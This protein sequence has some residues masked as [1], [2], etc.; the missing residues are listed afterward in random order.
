MEAAAA[1]VGMSSITVEDGERHR[2]TETDRQSQSDACPVV[3]GYFSVNSVPE[4]VGRR[5]GLSFV[6]DKLK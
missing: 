3:S 5:G 2:K 4:L 1:D 6:V